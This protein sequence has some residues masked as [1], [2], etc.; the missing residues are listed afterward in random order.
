MDQFPHH[1]HA[2]APP[3]ARDLAQA[4]RANRSCMI[5]L[6]VMGVIALVCSGVLAVGGV[7]LYRQPAVRQAARA[8]GAV[9]G[10]TYEA[11][12][13]PGTAELRRRG[14][15]QAM[16][17][18]PELLE[19][20]MTAFQP[21]AGAS[22]L[23]DMENMALVVCGLGWTGDVGCDVAARVYLDTRPGPT[24]NVAVT[25][26]GQMDQRPRCSGLYGP[27]GSRL[28]DLNAEEAQGVGQVGGAASGR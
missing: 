18:T 8:L 26:T 3:Q 5:L 25:V 6:V 10:I 28:R 21:D 19:R 9:A 24:E 11:M 13:A 2:Q 4:R 7:I 14:C 1:P 20:F 16:I 12:N 27:D 23:A 15:Q 17:F 22:S